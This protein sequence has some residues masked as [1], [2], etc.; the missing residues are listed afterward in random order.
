VLP[1]KS[2]PVL[3]VEDDAVLRSL[4]RATLQLEGFHVIAVEDGVDALRHLDVTRPA[5]VVLDLNLPRLNGRDV[6]REIK[7]RVDTCHIPI[8]I[9]TGEDTSD[10]RPEDFACILHKPMD[11]S[12]VVSAVRRC[13][14]KL[15]V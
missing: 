9:V 7:G 10:L 2:S 8:V 12:E 4:Y 5:V 11:P 1:A 3:I 6:Q 13:L 14:S 15:P